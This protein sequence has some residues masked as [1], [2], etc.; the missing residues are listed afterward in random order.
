MNSFH[1]PNE[2]GLTQDE[3]I[4]MVNDVLGSGR[5][6]VLSTLDFNGAPQSRWMATSS[7]V[8][9]PRFYTL[10]SPSSP[11]VEQ[12]EAHPTV[13]WMFSSSDLDL[14]VNLTGRA[15]MLLP[16][17]AAE[18]K[19]IWREI[20]DKSRAYFLGDSDR[21]PGFAIIET[22][23]EVCECTLPAQGRKFFIETDRIH[24]SH[25]YGH[26]IH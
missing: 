7:F 2:D 11:K 13:Q 23:V 9:F 14:V 6:G 18:V 15:R 22:T 26:G 16:D 19:K 20:V 25:F 21:G 3:I 5:P 17:N 1:T 4:G 8:E 12:I 10:T 24:P